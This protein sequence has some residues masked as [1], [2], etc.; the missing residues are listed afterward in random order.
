MELN[1]PEIKSLFEIAKYP[2]NKASVEFPMQGQYI[3]IELQ[4]D[5]SRIKFQSDINRGNRIANKVTLQLR[6]KKIYSI[7]RLDFLGYHR[8]P[9][10][11][12]PDDIFEG[13]EDYEFRQED[14]VH[15]YI[16][17][18]GDKWALPLSVLT[19]I[20]INASDDLYDKMIK[21]FEYCNV[22]DFRA[23]IVKNLTF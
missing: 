1:Q 11:P 4:N 7:R 22:Q 13:Y 18:Y 16:D 6:H 8:N 9:P 10:A 21:F 15:F 17:G 12:V 14:H 5:S 19:E 3:E 23:K 20:G 2:C